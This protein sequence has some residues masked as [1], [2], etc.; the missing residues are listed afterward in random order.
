[1]NSAEAAVQNA[2]VGSMNAAAGRKA[3]CVDSEFVVAA[4]KVLHER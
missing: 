2:R 3:R 1:V 4:S